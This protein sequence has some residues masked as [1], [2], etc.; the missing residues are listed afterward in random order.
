MA[1]K[2]FKI[3]NTYLGIDGNGDEPDHNELYKFSKGNSSS[4]SNTLEQS[5]NINHSSE[6]FPGNSYHR[7]PMNEE[8]V[9][10]MN[11]FINFYS[12]NSMK[13]KIIMTLVK[14]R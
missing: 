5:D 2:F 7:N 10:F 1:D 9:L 13:P 4:I 14:A 6:K 11:N 3:R 12:I 8:E